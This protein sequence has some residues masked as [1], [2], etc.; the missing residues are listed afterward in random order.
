M[1]FFERK[2][3]CSIVA[4]NVNMRETLNNTKELR[5]F[6]RQQVAEGNPRRLAVQAGH[7]MLGYNRKLGKCV[8]LIDQCYNPANLELDDEQKI[9]IARIGQFPIFTFRAGAELVAEAKARGIDAKLVLI[10]DD[11]S[12]MHT[13]KDN[14]QARNEFLKAMVELP[15]PYAQILAEL[16]LGLADVESSSRHPLCFP[17]TWLR[18]RFMR[19]TKSRELGLE[20]DGD[21]LLFEGTELGHCELGGNCVSE[22]MIFLDEIR[23]KAFDWVASFIPF[24]CRNP[25]TA[26]TEMVGVVLEWDSRIPVTNLFIEGSQIPAGVDTEK[27]DFTILVSTH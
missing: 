26:A 22:I 13:I 1:P 4:T 3:I 27:A 19:M 11:I 14:G 9:K 20:R 15:E 16:S 8:P 17:E 7:F 6:L 2:L 24:S 21:K 12:F 10:V 5:A 23:K 25:A 18:N